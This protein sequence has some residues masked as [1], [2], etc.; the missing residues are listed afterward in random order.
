MFIISAK[1]RLPMKRIVI[2]QIILAL[3]ITSGMAFAQLGNSKYNDPETPK[4]R[5]SLTV[6]PETNDIKELRA[7]ILHCQNNWWTQMQEH[8]KDDDDIQVFMRETTQARQEAAE[9]ILTL[10]QERNENTNAEDEKNRKEMALAGVISFGLAAKPEDNDTTFALKMLF[11]TYTWF[12][13]QESFAGDKNRESAK[14]LL[15]KF[16]KFVESLEKNPN[17][18]D[19]GM[20]ARCSWFARNAGFAY[21]LPDDQQRL[22]HFNKASGDIKKYI[23]ANAANPLMKYNVSYLFSSLK[24]SAES[25]EAQQ[26]TSIKKGTLVLPVLEYYDAIY[27]DEEFAKQNGIGR[28]WAEQYEREKVK[29]RV[30]MADNQLAV[31]REEVGKLKESLEKELGAN[32]I[33]KV[34]EFEAFTEEMTNRNESAR[35]LYQTIRPVFAAASVPAVKEYASTIDATLNLLALE[36][37]EFEFEA[38]LVDGKK[39]NLKDYRGK[40]VFL[41]YWRAGGELDALPFL[42]GLSHNKVYQEKGLVIIAFSVDGKVDSL[43]ESFKTWNLQCMNASEVLSKEQNLTDSREKYSINSFPTRIIIDKDGKV[44]RG[45]VGKSFNSIEMLA[46]KLSELLPMDEQK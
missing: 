41:T 9:K 29:Y 4:I 31:F 24:S 21:S 6:V 11:D 17:R 32:P 16:E 43:K 33:Q 36:G 20:R 5:A 42:V 46:R 22:A 28:N 23:T 15:G 34:G 7:F 40:V 44:V 1:E 45:S 2:V 25:I 18:K 3:F 13:N 26:G 39:I 38:V 8:F 30:L 35:V 37:K 27:W 14:E 19:F 12:L 10:V